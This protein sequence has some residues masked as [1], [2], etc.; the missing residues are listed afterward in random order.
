MKAR[1]RR[2]LSI[3]APAVRSAWRTAALASTSRVI[4]PVSDRTQM[5][6]SCSDPPSALYFL[7]GIVA[8]TLVLLQQ[9]N[10]SPDSPSVNRKHR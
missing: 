7:A 5:A 3:P 6:S 9:Q 2:S 10:T 4:L 8:G 1:E